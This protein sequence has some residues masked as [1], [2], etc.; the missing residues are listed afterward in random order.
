MIKTVIIGSNKM[1]RFVTKLID[2]ARVRTGKGRRKIEEIQMRS[3]E[4]ASTITTTTGRRPA[5]TRS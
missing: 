1:T 5:T 3:W 4:N 2:G